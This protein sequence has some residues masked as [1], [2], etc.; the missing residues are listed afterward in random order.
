MELMDECGELV[1]QELVLELLNRF[2]YLDTDRHSQCID[3]I[4]QKI[5]VGW[6]LSESET[7]IVAATADSAAD[8]GQLVVYEV[9]NAVG[10]FGWK[11]PFAVNRYDK[12]YKE[13]ASRPNIVLVDEFMGS[14]RTM[15]GRVRTILRELKGRGVSGVKIYVA[16]YAGMVHSTIP[17]K[18]EGC[19]DIFLGV[20]LKKGI[21]EMSNPAYVDRD[22][23][24][25]GKVE[26]RLAVIVNGKSL[27]RLGDAGSE[28][29]YARTNGNTPN[30]VFPVFWWPELKVGKTRNTILSRI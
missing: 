27:P 26:D 29:L 13:I 11:T 30:S 12:V 14:G 24:T 10:R 8:S 17:V 5:A 6:S 25:M 15:A 19:Q 2:C 21:S 4:A 3:K 9:K 1:E 28:A 16:S 20:E 22:L 7:Q 23:A 18:A